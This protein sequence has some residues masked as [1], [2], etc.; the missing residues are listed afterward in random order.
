MTTGTVKILSP[1]Q[2][3]CTPI[4]HFQSVQY[5]SPKT[6]RLTASSLF[7]P[8]RGLH[9]THSEAYPDAHSPQRGL[10]YCTLLLPKCSEGDTTK[11]QDGPLKDSMFY[12]QSIRTSCTLNT[13]Y[14]HRRTHT[15]YDIDTLEI[16]YQVKRRQQ[17]F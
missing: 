4:N 7:N 9:N 2:T 6:E 11:M 1:I 8:Q 5:Q 13:Q 3:V 14:K 16:Q 12:T 10:G 17:A 15:R